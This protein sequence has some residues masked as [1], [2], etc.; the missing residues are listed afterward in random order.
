MTGGVLGIPSDHI[1]V[2]IQLVYVG[3]PS[4]ISLVEVG[5]KTE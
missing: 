1:R 2:T 5:E 4:A 3:Y